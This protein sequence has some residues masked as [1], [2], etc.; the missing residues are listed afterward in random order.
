MNQPAAERPDPGMH[1]VGPQFSS[2]PSSLT[3]NPYWRLLKLTQSLGQPCEFY[4]P[5]VEIGFA[6]GD[7]GS[8]VVKQVRRTPRCL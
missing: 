8:C 1:R 5:Q 7:G 3:E 2:W 6:D 4:L